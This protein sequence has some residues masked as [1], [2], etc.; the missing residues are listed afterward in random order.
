N[1]YGY[2]DQLAVFDRSSS[3][4]RS[5]LSPGQRYHL[6]LAGDECEHQSQLCAAHFVQIVESRSSQNYHRQIGRVLACQEARMYFLAGHLPSRKS[7][8]GFCYP[9]LCPPKCMSRELQYQE[10]VG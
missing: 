9:C 6:G 7:S 8:E 4:G 1:S 3:P 5:W 10:S 2:G